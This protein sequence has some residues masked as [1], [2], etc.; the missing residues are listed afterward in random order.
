[1]YLN[2]F[3][4]ME[5]TKGTPLDMSGEGEILGIATKGY[6]AS[7]AWIVSDESYRKMSGTSFGVITGDDDIEYCEKRNLMSRPTEEKVKE[8]LPHCCDEFIKRTLKLL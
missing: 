4:I 3:V 8:L 5:V 6:F 1:M 7:E 2:N